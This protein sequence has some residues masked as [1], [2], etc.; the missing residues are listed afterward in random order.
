MVGRPARVAVVSGR[1]ARVAALSGRGTRVAVGRR[2]VRAAV[3]ILALLVS[4]GCSG[5][6]EPTGVAVA[7]DAA[8]KPASDPGPGGVELATVVPAVP[9]DPAPAPDPAAPAP[10][11]PDPA[12][13]AAAPGS[14]GSTP[15]APSTAAPGALS[16]GSAPPVPSERAAE[17]GTTASLLETLAV[18]GRA[19]QTGY[20]R[21]AY[22][23]AWADVDRNGC[24]TRNDI[25]RRDLSGETIRPGTNG[26]LVE[27]GTLDPDPYTGKRIDFVR[28]QT[29]S[30]AVQI[31]H[32]VALADSWVTGAFGWD[33]RKRIAFGNDPLNLLAVDGPA[34][35]Q[36]GASDAASWLPRA[37]YRCDY[38]ARQIAVKAK[39]ELWV[40]PAEHDAMARILASCPDQRSPAYGPVVLPPPGLGSAAGNSPAP[41]P[42]PAPGSTDTTDPRFEFCYQAKDAGY[43]PYV[44]GEDAEYPWYRD[45]DSDGV[46]CE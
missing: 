34:N 10:A 45:A 32:V 3:V 22:G 19:A 17:P 40:K 44:R 8:G 1:G 7:L 39:Y 25:L 46:V 24:D 35:S 18:K 28:G 9:S 16:P 27:A 15:S 13:D 6:E 5:D 20:A 4:G 37:A 33:E 43:G 26:C 41:K 29:T 12:P 14:A 38:V 30:L 2:R 36:K 31:D 11:V 42:S 21:E 23:Q